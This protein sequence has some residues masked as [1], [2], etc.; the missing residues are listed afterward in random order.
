MKHLVHSRIYFSCN[1]SD[2]NAKA[3]IIVV[4]EIV[5]LVIKMR[6]L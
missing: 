4:H 2:A 3:N 5:T 1:T 6:I